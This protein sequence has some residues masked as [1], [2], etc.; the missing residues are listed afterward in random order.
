RLWIDNM[1][2][3]LAVDDDVLLEVAGG[4]YSGVFEKEIAARLAAFD[5]LD[6]DLPAV[7]I[8]RWTADGDVATGCH[9]GAI[10]AELLQHCQGT[11]GGIAL[12]DAAQVELHACFR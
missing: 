5:R 6:A 11:V 7:G 3:A 2:V 4:G 1:R 12:G 10:N 9:Q 8:R